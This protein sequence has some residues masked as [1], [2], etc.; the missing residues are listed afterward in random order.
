MDDPRFSKL[1]TDPKF[2][3]VPKKERKVK[4]D[5]RFQSL[6]KDKKF[7]SKVSVD[8]RG[9]PGNFSTKENYEKFYQMDSDED[10]DS[11]ENEEEKGKKKPKTVKEAIKDKHVDYTR[12]EAVLSDS[13]SEE[14]TSDSDAEHEDKEAKNEAFDKWGE[15]DHDAESTDEATKRLAICNMDW[16]RVG[17]QDLF[18]VLSSFCS[19]KGQLV[20]VS[21]Y[22]SEFGKQRMAQEDHLGP[23]ELRSSQMN[24]ENSSESEDDQDL[25]EKQDYEKVRKYQI[26]RLKYYYAVAE[27]SSIEAANHVY[28]QCDGSEYELSATRFDLRFIPEDMEFND[29]PPKE[30]CDRPPQADQYKPKMFSTTALT[31]G[32]YLSIFNPI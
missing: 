22:P 28:T 26:N 17:A 19:S 31:L 2:R 7:V 10:E 30:V 1:F 20:K 4:I 23:Q 3:N 21:I 29:D 6:F 14:E 15:L 11:S 25:N 24:Q 8:K 16:D 12:G 9:R 18:L 5:N 13:S 27:F 32:K